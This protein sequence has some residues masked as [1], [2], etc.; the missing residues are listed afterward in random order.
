[1]LKSGQILCELHPD[2]KFLALT[3]RRCVLQYFVLDIQAMMMAFAA[4][5][6]GP[7]RHMTQHRPPARIST[8]P[9]LIVVGVGAAFVCLSQV[10]I[11]ILLHSRSWF[12]GGNGGTSQVRLPAIQCVKICFMAGFM[13]V[14]ALVCHFRDVCPLT[15]RPVAS[16][17]WCVTLADYLEHAI[18]MVLLQ[19]ASGHGMSCCIL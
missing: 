14:L 1:M 17:I 18:L 3:C 11:G 19:H 4:I 9:N 13:L 16:A 10:L 12:H 7:M 6:V 8:L 5:V 2:V 15:E